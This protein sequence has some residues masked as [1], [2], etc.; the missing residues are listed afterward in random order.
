MKI[1][2]KFML[3]VIAVMVLFAF[4]GTFMLVNSVSKAM[5]AEE[6]L[7]GDFAEQMYVKRLQDKT[8]DIENNITRIARKA[9]NEAASFASLPEIIHCY[10]LA[11]AGNIDDEA[12]STVQ[13]AREQL[14]LTIGQILEKYRRKTG[15]KE[16]RL[17]YHLPNNRSFVRTW[18]DGWQAKRNG[19]KVDI[20]D[21]LSS[22]RQTVVTVNQGNHQPLIGVEVGRGG[23]VIRGIVPVTATDGRHLGS[24]EVYYSFA[25]LISVSKS[26]TDQNL[27]L[28]AFMDS[29][30]LSVATQLQDKEKYPLL[31]D[32]YVLT[33]ASDPALEQLLSAEILDAGRKGVDVRRVGDHFVGTFPIRDFSGAVA[34]IFV[35][36]HTTADVAAMQQSMVSSTETAL[37]SIKTG[38]VGGVAV[39]LLMICGV[40]FYVSGIVTRPVQKVVEL[41]GMISRGDLSHDVP[42]ALQA[43]TDEIGDMAKALQSMEANL[44]DLLGEL[45]GGVETLVNSSGELTSVSAQTA[46]GVEN[47]VE[48][49]QSVAAAAEEAS[50][51]T[52]SV[53]SGMDQTTNSLSSVAGATEEM[54]ATVGEIASNAE[55][56]RTI[57][58]QAMSQTQAV[59]STMHELGEAAQEIDKVT[60]TITEI[61]SQTNLL[62]LNATIEAARAG[63]AGKGFAVVAGEI[64]ELARQTADATEDIKR[65]ISG[66]QLSTGSAV[67]DTNQISQVIREVSELVNSIAASIEEQSVVT[68]DVA[69]NIAQAS[70]EVNEA[71]ER[72]AQT[73]TVSQTIAADVAGVS[74]T[75]E[76]IRQGN[77]QVQ[78]STKDLEDLA[79]QLVGIVKKFQ[80]EKSR[81]EA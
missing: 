48:R 47:V 49:S 18:R 28:A 23:F 77:E 30:F 57:S 66:I 34:G 51:N 2:N 46:A 75:I 31:G 65:R 64:K 67:S 5:R 26:S 45:T 3:P 27:Q 9:L 22:F 39:V 60:E 80:L 25:S 11:L 74:A 12:D 40:I 17:H 1:R 7:A 78:G 13:S 73:A 62:A 55:K 59:S 50:S 32:K 56:A 38:M 24:C 41:L 36:T 69:G 6:Q 70:V 76:Q 16:V 54:S 19:K 37:S 33:V 43:R 68:R 15:I 14:R 21:D 20:S 63:A 81:S 42:A 44:R 29:S 8:Y 71:N 79:G 72:L 58:D 52:A 53:A 4:I 10:E 35:L 61:S